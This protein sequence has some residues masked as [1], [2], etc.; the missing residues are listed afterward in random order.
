M[1][2]LA[3]QSAVVTGATGGIGRAVAWS[4]AAD[5]AFVVATFHRDAC[6][7]QRLR[8]EAE[9]SGLRVLVMPADAGDPASARP[10]VAAAEGGGKLSI[11]VHAAGAP[12][13]GL[14]QDTGADAFH[15]L[16]RTH[17]GGAFELVRA[18]A[19]GMIR[20]R[21]GRIAFIGSLWGS[22][23]A[24]GESAYAAAKGG[25]HALARSLAQELGP[26]G[27]TVNVAAPGLINSGPPPPGGEATLEAF[28]AETPV[29]RAGSPEEVARLVRFLV[30]PGSGFITGQ[31]I[32]IDGGHP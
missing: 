16:W 27:I 4:L 5:G 10:P 12:F 20:R 23:G 28:R 24:A 19:P 2:P 21:Y 26:S 25:L 29:G 17:V 8:A 15:E 18:G 6:A 31:I 14:V 32:G 13:Y 7:A 3:G 1:G 22:R 11:L 9:A 30:D